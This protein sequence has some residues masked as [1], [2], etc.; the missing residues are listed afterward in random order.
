[1]RRPDYDFTP[2]F[3]APPLGP[4]ALLPG[5]GQFKTFAVDLA[6]HRLDGPDPL[7]SRKY[8]RDLDFVKSFGSLNSET[9][10]PD[11]AE[12]AFFWFE[13]TAIWNGIASTVIRQHNLDPWRAARTLALMNFALID[14]GI[15]CFEA[16]Y[17]FRFWRP[18]T[19]IRRAGEDGN[20]ATEPDAA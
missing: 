11:H 18:Y 4:V 19:A 2:P 6:K 9:R 15:V 3:D 16:K 14:A 12:T 5:L 7:R 8:A 17:H 13:E 1:L 20:E 10:T